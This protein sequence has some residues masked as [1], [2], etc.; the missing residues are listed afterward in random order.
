MS[1]YKYR[2]IEQEEENGLKKFS[3]KNELHLKGLGDYTADKLKQVIN[4][5]NR[6]NLFAITI[7]KTIQM[8]LGAESAM[9]RVLSPNFSQFLLPSG[10]T[11]A[12]SKSSSEANIA[13]FS[14]GPMFLRRPDIA[15]LIAELLQPLLA[16]ISRQ[17][18]SIPAWIH[19]TCP[20]FFGCGLL[21]SRI[22]LLYM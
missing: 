9:L 19:A 6:H 8:H 10:A 20:A 16:L 21:V 12:S 4:L 18:A 15:D 14:L 3:S 11:S 22:L 17:V 5:R 2:L 7:T 1:G 13:N